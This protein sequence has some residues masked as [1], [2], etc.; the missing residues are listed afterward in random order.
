V[1]VVIATEIVAAFTLRLLSGLFQAAESM[2]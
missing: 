2:S 1:I